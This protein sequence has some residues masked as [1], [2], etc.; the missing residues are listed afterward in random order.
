MNH[1][2]KN[3]NFYINKKTKS[4]ILQNK[5]SAVEHHKEIFFY[6]GV[7]KTEKIQAVLFY[8][9]IITVANYGY[10]KVQIEDEIILDVEEP[11]CISLEDFVPTS[12]DSLP[13]HVKSLYKMR[14]L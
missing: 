12:F 6:Q 13:N 5:E 3:S 4:I 1:Q 11:T 8:K 7:T 10:Q 14:F 9:R 2:I